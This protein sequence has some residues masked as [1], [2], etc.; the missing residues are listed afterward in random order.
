MI[1]HVA[2]AIFFVFH[3]AT[4]TPPAFAAPNEETRAFRATPAGVRVNV[5]TGGCT[6]KSDFGITVEKTA[7]ATVTIRLRRSRPDL[8]KGWFP[9][10]TWIEFDWGELEI[11]PGTRITIYET[12]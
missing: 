12:R 9:E 3:S 6:E 7:D 11:T 2:A 4:A 1:A 10:G 5:P 8:C